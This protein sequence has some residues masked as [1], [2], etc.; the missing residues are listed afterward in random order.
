MGIL[1]ARGEMEERTRAPHSTPKVE[2]F[3]PLFRGL[4]SLF[5]GCSITKIVLQYSKLP[6]DPQT[7]YQKDG[8]RP[9]RSRTSETCVI[10]RVFSYFRIYLLFCASGFYLTN[11]SSYY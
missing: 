2:F 3:P 4:F 6:F 8:S 7:K 5:P 9:F 1:T 11:Q 10:S